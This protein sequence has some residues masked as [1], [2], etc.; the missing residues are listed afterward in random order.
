M[1]SLG[2]LSPSPVK[3]V[4]VSASLVLYLSLREFLK[5]PVLIVVGSLSEVVNVFVVPDISRSSD[6]ALGLALVLLRN[7]RGGTISVV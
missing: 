2:V 4:S 1:T 6:L 7:F 5:S 3:F